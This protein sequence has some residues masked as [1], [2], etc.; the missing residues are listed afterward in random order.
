MIDRSWKAEEGR[1]EMA[2]AQRP[3]HPPLNLLSSHRLVLQ[4][5]ISKS[6]CFLFS[7]SC[8]PKPSPQPPLCHMSCGGRQS[9][10]YQLKL[11]C[12]LKVVGALKNPEIVCSSA[13]P[14]RASHCPDCDNCVL[15]CANATLPPLHHQCDITAAVGVYVQV[16]I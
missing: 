6:K 15:R 11:L 3:P 7:S 4:V 12:S 2:V 8:V 1:Q 13:R 5:W 10:F 9:G 16:L 14:P